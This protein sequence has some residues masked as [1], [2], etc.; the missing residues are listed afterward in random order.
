[1]STESNVT[2]FVRE[3]S[4]MLDVHDISTNAGSDDNVSPNTSN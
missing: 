2:I 4:D 3:M 1:M